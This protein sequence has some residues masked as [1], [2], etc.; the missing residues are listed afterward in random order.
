VYLVDE[1]TFR[2]EVELGGDLP[3]SVSN[4]DGWIVIPGRGRWSATFLTLAELNLL[5]DRWHQ[6]GEY[7]SGAYFTCPDLIL[8]REAGVSAMLFAVRDLVSTGAYETAL[9]RAEG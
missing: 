2:L 5:M 7:L 9:L 6:T 8:L 1:G 3:E 4:A